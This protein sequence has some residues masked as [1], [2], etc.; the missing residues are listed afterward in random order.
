MFRQGYVITGGDNLLRVR[1]I[2]ERWARLTIKFRRRGLS[3]EEY[4]YEIPHE[5]A[6]ELLFHASGGV[7]EKTRYTV[8]HE[9]FV[10]EVD[11]FVGLHIGLTI[12]EIEMAREDDRLP[13]PPWIGREVTGDKRYSNRSLARKSTSKLVSGNGFE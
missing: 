8:S 10:W 1:I 4:E 12:A 6:A 7:I 3:R 13:L 5:E 2:D 9:G 11:V